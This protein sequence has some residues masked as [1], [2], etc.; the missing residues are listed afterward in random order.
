MDIAE[1]Y[2]RITA[3]LSPEVKLIAVTK[4]RSVAEVLQLYDAGHRIMGE[5]KVQELVDKKEKLP[6]DIRWHM[7]GHLQT[8]KVKYIAPFISFI[9]S[10]DSVKLLKTISREAAKNNRIINCLLQVHIAREESK[11]GFS[12][13][14]ILEFLNGYSAEEYPG[15]CLRGLMGMATF[16]DNTALVRSEFK[17]LAELFERVRQESAVQSFSKFDELS[18]GMSD[19]YRIAVEEGSTMVRIGSLIFGER[20]YV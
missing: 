6:G 11:Y 16:T 9:H 20:T 13:S 1:N 8:N 17:S 2:K 19:D 3:G 7:I 4:S 5:N 10:V 14:A 12:K 18:M 15:V